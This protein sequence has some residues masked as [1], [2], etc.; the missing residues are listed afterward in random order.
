MSTADSLEEFG[1]FEE[2]IP[3]RAHVTTHAS[4]A[5]LERV[6]PQET[7]P[8]SAVLSAWDRSRHTTNHPQ[9]RA[10]DE[11]YLVYDIG[12][13]DTAVI[14]TVYPKDRRYRP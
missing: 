9:A 6:N 3:D 10:T 1:L 4:L 2:E 12:P 7:Y 5:W 14:L 13:D 11:L 8:A